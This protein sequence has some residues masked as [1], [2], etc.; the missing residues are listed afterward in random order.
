MP[1]LDYQ[2]PSRQT[3]RRGCSGAMFL[4]AGGLL[5]AAGVGA[6]VADCAWFA[7][8]ESE[9]FN[10]G[11]GQYVYGVMESMAV[12]G[13]ASVVVGAALLLVGLRRIRREPG[14]MAI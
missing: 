8:T 6:I 4:S 1:P 10:W 5:F 11:P 3:S 13:G 12:W 9:T 2:S 14:G 7:R